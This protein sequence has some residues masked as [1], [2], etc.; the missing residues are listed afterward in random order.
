M[1]AEIIYS[2]K[3][4]YQKAREDIEK[5]VKELKL[6]GFDPNFMLL[7]FTAGTFKDYKRYNE[8]FRGYF[9]DVQMMGCV[10]E[11]YAAGDE[12]WTIGI[13]ALLGKFEGEVKVFWKSGNDVKEICRRLGEEIGSEWNTILAMFPAFYFPSRMEFVR[14][15]LNDK[16]YYRRYRGKHTVEEKKEVLEEYSKYLKDHFI[17]PIDEV[18]KYLSENTGKKTPIIGMNLMPMEGKVGTPVVLANYEEIGRGIAVMCFKGKTNV[19]YHDI[20]PERGETFE[21]T[22]SVIK[23]Y[24]SNAEEV[25]VIKAEVAIGEING[26]SP[27]EFLRG[28]LAY[29]EVKEDAFLDEVET[30]KVETVS[31]YGLAFINRTNYSAFLLGLINSPVS[32][33]PSLANL[34]DTYDRAIFVGEVFRGGPKKFAQVVQNKKFY[35]SFDLVLIDLNTIPA[36][37]SG[38]YKIVSEVKK[39]SPR[40]FCIFVAHPSAF[41][42]QK[43][44]KSL[45]EFCSNVFVTSSGS[46][47][48]L[49][50]EA[51]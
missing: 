46:S 23:D 1:K 43:Y 13:A 17:F 44:K 38:V 28:R 39:S 20:F 36:F 45:I 42:P 34:H 9:P 12:I 31:P 27:V 30:G 29:D 26:K 37:K 18:L 32:I 49:E 4:E 15:F 47:A 6:S 41:L 48:I 51:K 2:P 21:N 25:E 19:I 3:N 35:D 8:L 10:V 22:V 14:L 33:Y 5:R 16:L 7:F 40:S 24:F 11:G 50:F